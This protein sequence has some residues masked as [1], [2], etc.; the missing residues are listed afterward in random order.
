MYSI[1]SIFGCWFWCCCWIC[2][3]NYISFILELDVIIPWEME[4][5]YLRNT[6]RSQINEFYW[7]CTMMYSIGP[8]FYDC[9]FVATVKRDSCYHFPLQYITMLKFSFCFLEEKKGILLCLHQ[10]SQYIQPFDFVFVTADWAVW[11][12]SIISQYILKYSFH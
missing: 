1:F 5:F 7:I 3:S 4:H 8:F 2:S 10:N 6:I 12:E 9:F 11:L